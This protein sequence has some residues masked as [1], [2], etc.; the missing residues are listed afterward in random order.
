MANRNEC[1]P[2]AILIGNL[3]ALQ[4]AYPADLRKELSGK[5]RI[6]DPELTTGNWREHSDVLG[7]AS[8]ALATWGVPRLDQEFLSLAPNLRAIFYAA[9]TVKGFM[10]PEVFTRGITVSNANKA[11]AIPVAEYAVS[12]IILSLKKFW[13]NVRRTRREKVWDHHL[14]GPGAY[15]S[16]VGLVS[17]GA[18]GR[19]TAEKLAGYELEVLAY[20]PF[21]TEKQAAALGVRLVSLGEIFRLSDVVSLHAPWLPETENLVNGRL[22]R[23][24]K[25]GATLL[26]TSRGAVINEE[27]LCA[28]LRERADLTAI[29]DVTYPEPPRPD[30]PLFEF[31]NV[32]MTPHISGSMAGEVTRMGRWMVDELERCL[33]GEPLQHAVTQEMLATAA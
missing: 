5:V 13:Q 9:G 6:L 31:D 8:F 14:Q 3:P 4:K 19:L 10:T 25:P 24:M 15:R 7:R 22:L 27:D 32:I 29:L 21:A 17:L 20:D 33:K 26:N 18:V 23:L 11:N 2:E 28:V 12:A 30:S 1:P 16:V